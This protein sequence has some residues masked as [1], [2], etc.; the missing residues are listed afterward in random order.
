MQEEEAREACQ[1]RK[2]KIEKTIRAMEDRER[3]HEN[4]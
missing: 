3:E 1:I 4:L 2:D